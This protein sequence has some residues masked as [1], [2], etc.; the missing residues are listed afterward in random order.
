MEINVILPCLNE[1]LSIG[2]TIES[3]R[4]VAPGARI[5]V[6]D[7]GS[8]DQTIEIALALGAE[9]LQEPNRGKGFA[10]R[11]GIANLDPD[12]KY[13]FMID[14]DDTYDVKK[15]HDGIALIDRGYDMVVG[16]REENITQATDRSLHYRRGHKSGNRLLT[17][18]YRKLF[19]IT[20]SDTLS[21]WRLMSRGYVDSF[22]GG[23]SGFEI[24]AELN[25]HA[26]T[27]SAAIIEIPVA[28][29]GR[30]EGSHSKLNTYKDGWAILRRNLALYKS[31]RPSLA[32]SILASPW[33]MISLILGVRVGKTYL[34][35]Q[36][37]PQFPSL[38]VGIATFIVAGNLWVTGMVLEHVRS[39]RVQIA[40]ALYKNNARNFLT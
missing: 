22:A 15:L 19:G 9:V 13:I 5:L 16:A 11:R 37:V 35:T 27:L 36:L 34:E 40:R 14:G 3:I 18:A 39:N 31:E 20:L 10:F 2:P 12:C 28:Y 23:A 8:S 30:Y 1:E 21:G 29:N 6:V 7:N 24:E 25:V 32:Y 26:Y 38:I 17:F 4:H 33:L